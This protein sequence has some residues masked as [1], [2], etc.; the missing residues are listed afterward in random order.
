MWLWQITDK[1][2]LT[3]AFRIDNQHMYEA[4]TIWPLSVIPASNYD[5]INTEWSANSG[6]VYHATD[7]DTIGGGF[8]RAVLLPSMLVLGGNI[9]F[10]FGPPGLSIP[11]DSEG[12]P[13]LKPTIVEN[14]ELD[15]TRKVP[16]MFSSVKFSPYYTHTKD[17]ITPFNIVYPDITNA[18][19]TYTPELSGNIGSSDAYGGEV[20][21]KGSHKGYRWATSYSLA[22][23]K[24]ESLVSSLNGYD[25]STPEHH[26][27]L[28]LGYSTGPW[29]FVGNGLWLSSTSMLRFANAFPPPVNVHVSDYYSFGGRIGYNINDKLA[30]ALMGTNVTRADT[31]ESPYPAI[32]RQVF[33]SLTGKF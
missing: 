6:F 30:L 12:N 20:E 9:L 25:G 7:K 8:G 31:Q 24:D 33:L 3:N 23:V 18:F 32:Q 13:Y 1:L 21:I 16:E 10:N 11:V 28:L 5:H 26:V 29:E 14:Y 22:Y 19:N 15:Y 17:I 27:R 2:S 4:G